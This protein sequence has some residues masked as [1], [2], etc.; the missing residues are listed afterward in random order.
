MSNSRSGQKGLVLEEVLKAYFWHAGY[1]VVRAVPYRYDDEDVTDIDLW[2]YE[3]P[4]AATRRRLIVDVKNRRSPKAA[5][6]IIWSRGLQMAL[7]VD[8]AVVATTD[9]RAGARRLAKNIGVTLFDGDAISKLAN[10]KQVRLEGQL[11]YENLI[12][13]IKKVDEARRSTD[14]RQV[15]QDARSS[16]AIGLGIQ[17]VNRNLR[18]A[19]FFA[20]QAIFAQ[21]NSDQAE[22]AVRLLFH[23]CA[24]ATIS[25][26]FALADHAFRSQD[27][28]RQIIVNGIRY[29]ETD[30]V[31]A[32]TTVRA[33]IALARKYQDNGAAA[34]KQIE[35]GFYDDAERIP[36]DIIADYVA[37]I[38]TTDALFNAA[39]E[40]EY[41]SS[42]VTLPSLDDL[43][44]EAKSLLGTFLDFNGISREKVALAWRP[45]SPRSAK[46]PKSSAQAPLFGDRN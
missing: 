12:A 28:K 45:K 41:A 18:A 4:A 25:L 9:K 38:S 20:E 2:L 15:S 13:A 36:A 27:E 19:S 11:P 26:D 14:W 22:L 33:A 21:A 40:M 24:L 8:G 34:A 3:R 7:G 5:E 44:A 30:D 16:L 42:A 43:T 23:T 32:I 10:S 35:H 39:R 29:G 37:R 6:R 17:T 1:F 31:H 46:A